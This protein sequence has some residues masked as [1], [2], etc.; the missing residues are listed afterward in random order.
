MKMSD[1]WVKVMDHNLRWK[2]VSTVHCLNLPVYDQKSTNPVE[3]IYVIGRR[4]VVWNLKLMKMIGSVGCCI[5]VRV[6][7]Y[8]QVDPPE[9]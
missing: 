5:V 2:V 4:E 9:S 3:G 6:I 8:A 7:P 1:G